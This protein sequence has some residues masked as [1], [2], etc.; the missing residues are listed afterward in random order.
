MAEQI[1]RVL[2]GFDDEV[3]EFLVS[4][5][6]WGRAG[7][8][9]HRAGL[10]R[11]QEAQRDAGDAFRVLGEWLLAHGYADSDVTYWVSF[12]RQQRALAPGAGAKRAGGEAGRPSR[13]S[14]PWGAHDVWMGVLAAA[15]TYGVAL[16]I[17]FAA[18]AAL[19]DPDLDVWVAVVPTL[20]ELLFLA[21]VW[22]FALR[23]PGGSLKT[24]GFVRFKPQVLAVGVGLLIC[25]F[26]FN[27]VY[28]A[29]L[30]S[31]G[32]RVQTDL[33]PLVRELASPWPL[34]VTVVLVAPLVEE[35]FFRGFVFAGL[36]SR[37]DWRWAAVISGFLFSAAHMELTFFLPGFLLGFLFAYLYQRSN[38]I[39]P[40]V[41]IHMGM[42][43]LAMTAVYLQL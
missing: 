39:W 3:R 27:G 25:F 37:Y 14:V 40:G 6:L 38:S 21:P 30:R 4:G 8:L 43:A 18:T 33:T 42:N 41:I 2:E 7:S 22:W 23:K 35:T 9:V 16:G 31:F 26:L 17:V 15:A 24:L 19:P 13:A 5:A 29:I 28:A 36:R 20:L 10:A 12:L 34:I 11:S 32:L 1:D